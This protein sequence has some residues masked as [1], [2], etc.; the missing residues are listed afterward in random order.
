MRKADAAI[1]SMPEPAP[2]LDRPDR[3]E[4]CDACGDPLAELVVRIDSIPLCCTCWALVLAR[5]GR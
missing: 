4:H 2:R 5:G 3:R 1:H